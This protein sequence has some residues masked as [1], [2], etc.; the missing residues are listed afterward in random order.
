MKK[1]FTLFALLTVLISGAQPVFQFSN[2][3]SPTAGITATVLIGNKPS[4]PGASGA[5]VTWNFSSL[6][7][8]AAGTASIVPP[9]STPFAAS[10]TAATSSAIVALPTGTVYTYD[11]VQPSF[12]DQLGDGISA[13]GGSTYTPDP[14]RHMVFPFNYGNSYS[15]TYQCISCSPS[16]FTVTY[17]AWGTL[18]INGKTYNNVARVV[19]M[20]GFPYYNYYSTNPVV[21]IFAYD[22]SPSSSPYSTLIESN[23]GVG[24]QE[25]YVVEHMKIFP[26]PA[27]ET[28]HIRN[29]N[30]MQVDVEIYDM[31]G[32][33]VKTKE[34]LSQ[35]ASSTIDVST[36]APGLYFLKFHDEFGNDSYTKLVVE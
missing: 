11:N 26:N 4:S 13:T 17:D 23:A 16:S 9:S 32:K 25:N 2:M 6:T 15:D 18:I 12:K 28:L 8:T 21:S 5:G 10:F 29:D 33:L 31:M 20:F 35:G 1:T 19:N 27:G 34:H 14:K 7:F 3:P 22:S 36:C 24:I 30:F